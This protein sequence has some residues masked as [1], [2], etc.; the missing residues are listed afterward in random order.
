M[1]TVLAVLEGGGC[2]SLGPIAGALGLEPRAFT[3]VRKALAAVKAAPAD[4]VVAEFVYAPTYGARESSLESLVAALQ[5]AGSVARLIVLA[6][7]LYERIW[8]L[9]RAGRTHFVISGQGHEATEV[10]VTAA[11]TPAANGSCRTTARWAAS[12]RGDD[13]P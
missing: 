10:G 8:I 4:V 12:S 9:N 6:R 11:L 1:A 2:P 3:T 7:S 5:R 13:T